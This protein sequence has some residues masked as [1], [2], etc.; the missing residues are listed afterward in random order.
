[1]NFIN[2][3]IFNESHA[4]IYE[5]LYESKS[6]SK[7]ALQI[8]S[9]LPKSLAEKRILE[10]GCGTGSFTRELSR[11]FNKKIVAIDSSLD[12]LKVAKK[13]NYE[14]HIE[15]IHN[16]V[17]NFSISETFSLIGLFFH[18]VSYLTTEEEIAALISLFKKNTSKNDYVVFDFWNCKCVHANKPIETKKM[19]KSNQELSLIRT[20][21]PKMSEKPHIWPLDMEFETIDR[22][23]VTT[24][25][26][27]ERHTMRCFST[28]F[29]IDRL[30]PEFTLL[31]EW[32]L[33]SEKKYSGDKYGS[34]LIF[35][36]TYD[37]NAT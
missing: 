10:I 12:M 23:G 7:M 8:C 6:H 13:K 26:T 2:P 20:V 3:E 34:V 11:I 37:S 17:L 15:F 25:I 35:E 19:F 33:E 16:D 31:H 27:N 14:S 32:D 29:W 1:M 22:Q 36:R 30:S 24:K 4:D 5:I 28:K 9:L 18:V 21:L